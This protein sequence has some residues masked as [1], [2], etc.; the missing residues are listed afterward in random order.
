MITDR[1]IKGHYPNIHPGDDWSELA[2]LL[3]ANNQIKTVGILAGT[4]LINKLAM[5][6]Y[7]LSTEEKVGCYQYSQDF[8]E[9]AFDTVP[10][11]DYEAASFED[12]VG[13]AIVAASQQRNYKISEQALEQ[14]A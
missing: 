11:E 3:I 13:N 7:P 9:A 1:L 4:L 5:H 10:P 12:G 14:I 6:D 8:L 2:Q